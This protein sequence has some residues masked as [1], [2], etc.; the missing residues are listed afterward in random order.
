MQVFNSLLV[1]V[2]IPLC[3]RV[4]YPLLSFIGIRRPLQ[5]MTFGGVL[6]GLSFICSMLVQFQIDTYGDGNVLIAAQLP[7]YALLT[8]GE[9]FKI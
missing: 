7:Q 2:F 3:N 5:K 9:V 1:L 6:I 8:L 4:V